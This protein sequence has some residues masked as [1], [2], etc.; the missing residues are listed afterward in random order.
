M[1]IPV[2]SLDCISCGSDRFVAGGCAACGCD[3][4][5]CAASGLDKN[6]FVFAAINWRSRLIIC[7]A[8]TCSYVGQR[9]LHT[10]MRARSSPSLLSSAW[11]ASMRYI[12]KVIIVSA[13]RFSSASDCALHCGRSARRCARR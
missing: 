2:I 3:A 8:R 11:I 7:L 4:G 6:F 1:R 12:S 10:G 9:A 13:R 5:G